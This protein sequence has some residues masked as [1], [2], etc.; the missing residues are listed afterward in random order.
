M[1]I[2]QVTLPVPTEVYQR[3][4]RIAQLSH[5][6][7][8]D[9]LVKSIQLDEIDFDLDQGDE[10]DADLARE[11][12]AYIDL[13]PQLLVQFPGEYVAIHHGGVVDHDV[14]GVALS[15]RVY[16]QFP[17]EFVWIAPIQ[18]QAIEEWVIRSPRF[19][20]IAY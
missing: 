11:R 20:S 13:H 15:Q 19:E 14:D 5:R 3:A 6:D 8:A 7:V 4:Q 17:D 9:V 16:K 1:S 2:S 12:A 10:D 18:S